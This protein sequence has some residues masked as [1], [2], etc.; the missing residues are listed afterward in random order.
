[1][2]AR[3]L[4]LWRAGWA[5]GS[6]STGVY[7]RIRQIEVLPIRKNLTIRTGDSFVL[8]VVTV[9]TLAIVL[10]LCW[11]LGFHGDAL[12]FIGSLIGA[13]ATIVAVRLTISYERGLRVEDEREAVLPFIAMSV[14]DG[15]GDTPSYPLMTEIVLGANGEVSYRSRPRGA[16]DSPD[17]HLFTLHLESVGNGPAINVS[18]RLEGEGIDVR[19]IEGS[20][21]HSPVLQFP[22]GA[23][24][25]IVLH[26]E[27]RASAL[28]KS[29]A[30]VLKYSDIHGRTYEQRHKL[31]R[32]VEGGMVRQ[33]DLKS[34]PTLIGGPTTD[35]QDS[36]HV[37][38][39]GR[40]YE[41]IP[42]GMSSGFLLG[43]SDLFGISLAA[44][45][46]LSIGLIVAASDS[47]RLIPTS[48]GC[49]PTLTLFSSSLSGC[50]IPLL[51][52]ACHLV[53]SPSVRRVA[54]SPDGDV[55]AARR[56]GTVFALLFQLVLVPMLV[57]ALISLFVGGSAS[58]EQFVDW[59]QC[60]GLVCT[61]AFLSGGAGCVLSNV[62]VGRLLSGPRGRE[63]TRGIA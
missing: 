1:M 38:G 14:A 30:F 15:F 9:G 7:E 59:P 21:T 26:F 48:L 8:A 23:T 13:A 5:A 25:S 6:G 47:L 46:A 32:L 55:T 41:F 39:M 10:L 11:L 36:G 27:S 35:D 22:I 62:F 29:L 43:L 33:F 54:V 58:W 28:E 3:P 20:P 52:L 12:A 16:L 31:M 53:C 18:A 61:V 17:E 45:F 51:L 4:L 24:R 60:Q 19:Y 63:S 40:L 44:L 42:R 37:P 34:M 56:W 50:S 2:Q 49:P 57:M